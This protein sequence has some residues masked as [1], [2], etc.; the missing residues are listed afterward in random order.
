MEMVLRINI[1]LL[2]WRKYM[3]FSCIGGD[4]R[5]IEIARF[6][7]DNNHDVYCFGLPNES[8]LYFSNSLSDAVNNTDY[9]ILP[10]PFSRDN[11]TVFTPLKSSSIYLKDLISL[12]PKKIYGGLLSDSFKNILTTEGIDFFDY[13]QCEALTIKNAVLTAE[14]AISIAISET[15]F[16]LLGSNCLV[17][18]YGR[19][20]KPLSRYLKAIGANVTATS[21]D[22]NTL[23]TIETDG[24]NA[25]NT[26]LC[27]QI[28][29]NYNVIFNTAP[30]PILNNE[31]FENCNKS[32][33][34]IDLA[35]N[36]GTD[37]VSASKYK[38]K[39]ILCPGLPGKYSPKT[40][41]KYIAEE[42]LKTLS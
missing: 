18:G 4:L 42:I 20:G 6:L 30:S 37:F 11:E 15:N 22:I 9:I 26:D 40:A 31:L 14:A 27:T 21:R 2:S 12:K 23:T 1:S 10:L 36:A 25:I 3:K 8:D 33:L 28:A 13:Y 16:S 24:F 32:C 5:Q 7:K 39:A 41:A 17:I 35:T 38:I 29:S 34:V 19:I